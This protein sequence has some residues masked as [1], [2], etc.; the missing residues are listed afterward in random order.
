MELG[1]VMHVELLGVEWTQPAEQQLRFSL[2][3]ERRRIDLSELRA[4]KGAVQHEEGSR[5]LV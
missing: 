1:V 5:G 3:P 2:H 4:F